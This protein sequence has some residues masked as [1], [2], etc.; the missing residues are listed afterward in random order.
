MLPSALIYEAIGQS[1]M[2]LVSGW[3]TELVS[4]KVIVAAGARKATKANKKAKEIFFILLLN[5][6][7]SVW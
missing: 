2:A 4:V 7:K 6:V 1:L 3:P 5:C